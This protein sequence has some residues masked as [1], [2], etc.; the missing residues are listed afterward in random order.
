M[1]QGRSERLEIKTPTK[2]NHKLATH[3]RVYEDDSSFLP[4][5]SWRRGS[6]QTKASG[7]T[8]LELLALFDT[9]GYRRPSARTRKDQASAKRTEERRANAKHNKEKKKQKEMVETRPN[10]AEEINVFKRIVQHV[11]RQDMAREQAADLKTSSII[12]G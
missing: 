1:F 12:R 8:W 5:Q 4:Q 7:T 3:R 6:P 2:G 11:A 9:G 10:L